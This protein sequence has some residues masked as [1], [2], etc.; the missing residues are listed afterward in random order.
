MARVDLDTNDVI[1]VYD[2]QLNASDVPPENG[3]QC[4]VWP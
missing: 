4:S 2:S 3:A 1:S